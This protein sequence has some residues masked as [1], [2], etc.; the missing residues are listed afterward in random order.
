MSTA[1]DQFVP[2]EAQRRIFESK[3][4]IICITGAVRSGKTMTACALFVQKVFAD[5]AGGKCNPQADRS[6]TFNRLKRPR[7]LYYVVAP[8]HR[9]LKEARAYILSFFPEGMYAAP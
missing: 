3:A 7:L 6:R 5:I 1:L 4:R 2:T 8:V 9:L